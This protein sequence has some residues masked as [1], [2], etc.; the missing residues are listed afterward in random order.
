MNTARNITYGKAI[1]EATDL[2]LERDPNVIV[3]GLG[4]PDPKRIFGTTAGLSEKYGRERVFDTQIA[5]NALTGFAVG[6]ATMGIRPLLVHMRLDFALLSLDQIFNNAAKWHYM[7]GGKLKC[8]IT[9]RMLV[10]RGWGQGPQHS[11]SY[12]A[13]FAHVP[14]LK[15]VMPTTPHDAKGLLISAIEDDSPVIYIEHRWLHNISGPV[16]SGH[17]KE[18]LCKARVVRPGKDITIVATS[19]MVME[20]FRAAEE[21]ALHGFDAEVIDLRTIAPYDRPAILES[22]RKTGRLIVADTGHLSF[23]VA[24]EIVAW[25]TENAFASLKAAPCRIASPDSPAPTTPGLTK[26]YYPKS[27]TIAEKVLA[28]MGV[29]DQGKLKRIVENLSL[30]EGKVPSDKPDLAFTGPF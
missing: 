30:L 1:C 8:P 7:F 17:F 20:A 14:G 19:Y 26:F 22:V 9:I 10:G 13:L 15:V 24:S 12:Q 29:S 28:L 23:G 27:Q 21:L 5:E 3:Y 11:S 4:V 2:C 18:P 25:T 16:A 6:A